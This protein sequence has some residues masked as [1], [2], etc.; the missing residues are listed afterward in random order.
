MKWT[1]HYQTS[2]TPQ[3]QPIPGSNQKA[4]NA[5]GYAWEVSDWTQLD[6]FLILGSEGGTFYVGE[7]KL[8]ID[9]AE[10]VKRCIELDGIR[11]VNRIAEISESGRAPKNDPA[12]FALAMCAS[13]GNEQTRKAALEALPRVARIGTHLFHFMDFVQGFRG[14][15]RG[16]RRAI[17]D[18]YNQKDVKAL[19]LLAVK[20]RQRDG[21]THRDALRLAH[22]K[23]QSDAHQKLYR[24]ITQDEF[25]PAQGLEIVDAFRQAQTAPLKEVVH[26]IEKYRLPREAIPT[27]FLTR[28]EVWEAMLPHMPLEAM[29]RNLANMTR[30]G[31]LTPMS[32]SQRLVTQKLGNSEA[33]L[34]AR[35]HPIKVLAALKTYA[36]GHG[37]RGQGTSWTPVQQVVDALDAAFYTAFGSVTPTGK[38]MML[39]LDVSGSMEAGQIA[40]VPGLTPR[41]ASA[42]MALVTAAVEAQHMITGFSAAGG[43]YGGQWGGGDPGMTPINIS[44]RQRLDDVVRTVARIPMGGTDCSLPMRHALKEKIEVDAFVVYTDSETWYGKIHPA[45][46]LQQ[47]RR[48]MGIPAKLIVVGMVANRFSIAD[49][50]DAGMLDVVGFDTAT[51]EVMGDFILQ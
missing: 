21:W 2:R 50:K 33:I 43:G 37:M 40:G 25:A 51:P 11:T 10:A 39:A 36:A 46:A 38:R 26:L 17:G 15:G 1:K 5:G 18:W 48:E 3:N 49:P 30:I 24:W 45:Q 13:F 8:T 7:Q 41:V 31:L 28:P 9:N 6:R 34:K 42:A 12:L 16:L 20:Y 27:E 14:W 47:Y 19:A 44:P 29:V 32:E 23:A 22:P 35:L 4:N